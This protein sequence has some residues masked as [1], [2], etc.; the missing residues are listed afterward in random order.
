[1]FY[2]FVWNCIIQSVTHLDTMCSRYDPFVGDQSCATFVLELTTFILTER[3]LPRPLSVTGNIATYNQGEQRVIRKIRYNLRIHYWGGW[4]FCSYFQGIQPNL[5]VIVLPPGSCPS[6][7]FSQPFC[8]EKIR[9]TPYLQSFPSLQTF[10]HKS[11]CN[12]NWGWVCQKIELV[13]QLWRCHCHREVG[14]FRDCIR[15]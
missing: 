10:D 15:K 5:Q 8:F 9:P 13:L 11:D 1:M 2:V 14:K 12:E 3:H 4:W 7:V 6:V